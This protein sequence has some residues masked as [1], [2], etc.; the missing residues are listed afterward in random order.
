M[1]Q[2]C[3]CIF[4]RLRAGSVGTVCVWIYTQ[5]RSSDQRC[6]PVW[7]SGKALGW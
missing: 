1:S 7:P 3:T 2:S 4:A 5:P 6:E